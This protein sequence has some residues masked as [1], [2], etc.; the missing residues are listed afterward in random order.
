MWRQG[1]EHS[2]ETQVLAYSQ[3]VKQAEGRRVG[4]QLVK[5]QSCCVS[6]QD[7]TILVD[8]G[9]MATDMATDMATGQPSNT[10]NIQPHGA[11]HVLPYLEQTAG[12]S[13]SPTA[14]AT[15]LRVQ[16]TVLKEVVD[17]RTAELQEQ[18]KQQAEARNSARYCSVK[19]STDNTDGA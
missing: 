1:Q 3:R 19:Q 13:M 11:S 17:G 4:T 5:L 15:L 14:A 2:S 18:N 7:R 16:N 6:R 9:N 10:D 12:L 8:S